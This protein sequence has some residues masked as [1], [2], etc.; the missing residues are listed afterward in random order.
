M[1]ECRVEVERRRCGGRRRGRRSV[2]EIKRGANRSC[3]LDCVTFRP[4]VDVNDPR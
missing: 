1:D 2:S 4:D 3:D